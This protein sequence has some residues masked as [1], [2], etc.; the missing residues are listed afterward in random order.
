M[1]LAFAAEQGVLDDLPTVLDVTR[2]IFPT[3]QRLA[4]CI[5]EDPEIAND[6]HILIEVEVPLS[7]AQA[8]IAQRQW[9]DESFMICPAP[10]ICVFRLS[11]DLVESTEPG[12]ERY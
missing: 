2:R 3:A 6:R 9:N 10:L 8:H 12:A 1:V 11:L 7:V 5:E 4:V